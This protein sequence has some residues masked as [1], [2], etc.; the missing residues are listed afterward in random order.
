MAPLVR[1]QLIQD[2][3]DRLRRRQVSAVKLEA[4]SAIEPE[5]PSPVT[6]GLDAQRTQPGAPHAD[7]HSR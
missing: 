6:I 7:N 1:T 4:A 2:S 5:G 3:I